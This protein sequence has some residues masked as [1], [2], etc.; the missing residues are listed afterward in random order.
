MTLKTIGRGS[1]VNSSA[2]NTV[3]VAQVAPAVR[4]AIGEQF[5][6]DYGL[7]TT[8]Q[9]VA[10]MKRM[11]FNIVYDTSFTADL[12]VV[13]EANEFAHRLKNGGGSGLRF[14]STAAGPA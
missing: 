3:V 2:P 14:T 7:N 13:E 8:G 4:V 12:T 9:V 10:A 6:L 11:G 5:G 1:N